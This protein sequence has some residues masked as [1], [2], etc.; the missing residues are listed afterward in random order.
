METAKVGIREFRDKL[1]TYVL[2]SDAPVAITRHG[3]TVGYFLPV[4]RKRSDADR[5]ALQEAAAKWQ[6]IMDA[7]GIDEDEVVAEFKRRRKQ[8][9]R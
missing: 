4:R 6:A 2:E 5:A 3:D 9:T 7:E 8:W 1:A